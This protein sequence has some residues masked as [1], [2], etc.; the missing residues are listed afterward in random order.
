MTKQNNNKSVNFRLSRRTLLA[1]LPAMS[2]LPRVLSAQ[3]AP[4]LSVKKINCFEL[5]VSDP[6][7]TVAFY[8]D[9]FGMPVQARFGERICLRVGEGPQFMAI[10]RLEAGETP[11]ITYIGYSVEN[12][13]VQT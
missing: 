10:R 8:Q 3:S 1:S 4:T 6:A 13:D 9:L 2:L 11:A 12:F 5:R 7:R